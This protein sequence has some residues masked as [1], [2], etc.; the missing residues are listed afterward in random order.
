[1]ARSTFV[2]YLGYALLYH[3]LGMIASFVT[4]ILIATLLD[5]FGKLS[6]L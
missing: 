2:K 4:V 6:R 5:A 1:M 3:I